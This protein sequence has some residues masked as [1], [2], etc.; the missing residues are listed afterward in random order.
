MR[1]ILSFLFALTLAFIA[2]GWWLSKDKPAPKEAPAVAVERSTETRTVEPLPPMGEAPS[3]APSAP[4]AWVPTND[5]AGTVTVAGG[6]PA[7]A[8]GAAD[9]SVEGRVGGSAAPDEAQEPAMRY[10][11]D[12]DG[13]KAAVSDSKGEI[14]TC[15]EA[16][17]KTGAKIQ[18]KLVVQFTIEASKEEGAPARINK[19]ALLDSS[20]D[21]PFMEGCVLDVMRGLKFD[22]PERGGE[23][24]VKYPF[25]FD[26]GDSP[27]E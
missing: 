21:H 4:S 8:A 27:E 13:I 10:S 16:W 2:L 3:G 19:A 17:L 15:Y 5:A 9:D 14:K 24:T 11:I 25:N 12:R 6:A 22:P 18:G 7:E 26:E 1:A 23:V 20:L